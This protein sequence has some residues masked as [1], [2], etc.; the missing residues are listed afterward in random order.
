[1]RGVLYVRRRDV[2]LYAAV[3]VLWCLLVPLSA[4]ADQFTGKVVGI[5]DGDTISV[6]REGKAVKVRLYGID[7][8]EKA[9]AFGTQAR[10]FTSDLVFQRDVTVVVHTTDRYGRLVGEVLLPDGR[11]LNQELVKA[12]MAWWYRP[13]APNDPALAQL[14]AEARTAKRGLWA[15][16]HPV[17]PWQWRKGQRESTHAAAPA[18]STAP[19]PVDSPGDTIIGNK[20]SKVYH[21]PGCPDYDKVSG[22]NRVAFPSREAAE[23]AGYRPAGNCR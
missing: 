16:A 23:Q 14:E 9:Q 1:M 4:A 8:P 3:V 17:P 6:L 15:D 20:K 18:A 12:G 2:G 5:S 13:Y 10:K 19:S 7:A 22:T 21:W 11:S